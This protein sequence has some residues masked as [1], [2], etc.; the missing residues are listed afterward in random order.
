MCLVA[1]SSASLAE[2]LRDPTRPP[3]VL[4]K[5]PSPA[6]ASIPTLTSVL[7]GPDRRVAVIDGN[8]LLEGS[9]HQGI[10][11]IKVTADGAR[12]RKDG[13]TLQLSLSQTSTIKERREP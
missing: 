5:S 7:I 2:P 1:Y 13:M 3:T 9:R 10:E 12:I 11:V 4:V 6:H 8:T